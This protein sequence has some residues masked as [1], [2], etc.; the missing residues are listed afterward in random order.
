MFYKNLKLNK[1]GQV[2]IEAVIA[3]AV[4]AFVM[5]GI[6]AALILSVNNATF[7]K[8]QNLATN[9]AQEGI[10]IARDLKDSDFQAF[11]T[12]Q[13][14]YCI[15]EGDIAIDP[16]KTT[17]SKNVDSAFTR[18]VYINQNGED[19]RQSLAQRG[20]E[21][22]LAFVASIVTW[23]DSRCQGTAECH[24]VELNSCFADLK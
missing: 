17:C 8:N 22:N 19:A 3:I 15:D 12:L 18:R 11:S 23:N 21:A 4:V 6:V 5:S 16:S 20:C 13:G 9:F 24:E 14:Y 1:K 2:L 10:D 7:S